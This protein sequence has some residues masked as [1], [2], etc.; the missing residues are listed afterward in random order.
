[1]TFP[2]QIHRLL[3]AGADLEPDVRDQRRIY[4]NNSIA[5]TLMLN[6]GMYVVVLYAMGLRSLALLLI[7]LG[8][9]YLLPVWFNH[10]GRF[11]VSRIVLVTM[12]N[13]IVF[14]YVS[15]IGLRG[16]VSL[17]F[18]AASLPLVVCDLGDRAAIAWGI[19]L[20][21]V[22]ALVL[23]IWGGSFMGAHL[24]SPPAEFTFRAIL[25]VGTFGILLAIVL[26][27]VV[28][29]VRAERSL[30]VAHTD[31]LRILVERD[32]SEEKE[33]ALQLELAQA[34]KLESVGRLA[35]GVAHEINTPIQYVGDSIHFVRGGIDALRGL[36][37]EYQ[38]LARLVDDGSASREDV[39]RIARAEEE[40]D[41]PYLL[42]NVPKALERAIDGVA[43]V[44]A[45]VRSMKEFAH[46]DGPEKSTADLNAALLSTLTVASNSY[47]SVADVDTQL[48]DLPQVRCH[49]GSLNQ[50]FLNL[51]VNA[52]DS[53][54]EVVSG[55]DRKGRITVSSR[56]ETESESV[57][58]SV[59]DTGA[60]IPEDIRAK[61]FDQFFTTKSVGKGTGQGLAIARNIVAT[62]GGSIWFDSEMGKGTTFF[63]RIPFG[64]TPNVP[65][66]LL[67]R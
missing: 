64:N 39:Q 63:I 50:V 25:I 22:G 3:R 10:S 28:S 36:A 23:A 43:R 26:S 33:K 38:R 60:G 8:A 16:E 29:N 20:S 9:S 44:A 35:A 45:I 18:A 19:G 49:L 21:V 2:R 27:F 37:E 31:I 47:K 13:V 14:T 34:H 53:I 51:I 55:S 7:P 30:R 40:A 66:V 54:G 1:L 67:S 6:T 65:D 57:L 15:A 11:G 48:Q 46:P 58:I 59:G 4:V 52:A 61:I 17:F 5:L 24:L 42:D 41:L 56:E 62:H 12:P 32:R